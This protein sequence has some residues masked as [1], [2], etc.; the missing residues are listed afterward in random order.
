MKNM[1]RTPFCSASP[2]GIGETSVT[3]TPPFRS[4]HA[5]FPKRFR[6]PASLPPALS[7]L[8]TDNFRKAV[9]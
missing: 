9:M 8:L 7:D 2:A 4:T 5:D 3:S 6:R 1:P